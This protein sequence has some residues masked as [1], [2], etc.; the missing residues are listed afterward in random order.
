ML[1]FCLGKWGAQVVCAWKRK[2]GWPCG[3]TTVCREFVPNFRSREQGKRFCAVSLGERSMIIESQ[4][5][6]YVPR[7]LLSW[8]T[9][10]AIVDEQEDICSISRF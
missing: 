5:L 9:G 1:G 6:F 10:M 4:G 8:N 2:C 7:K 3:I